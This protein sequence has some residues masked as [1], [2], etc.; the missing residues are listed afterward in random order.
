MSIFKRSGTDQLRKRV[1]K[2]YQEIEPRGTVWIRLHTDSETI[3]QNK[4]E[5]AWSQMMKLGRLD[6]LVTP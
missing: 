1:P 6:W 3:A 2:R 5:R 4:A